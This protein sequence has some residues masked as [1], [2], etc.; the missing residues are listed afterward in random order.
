MAFLFIGTEDTDFILPTG[1]WGLDTFGGFRSSFVRCSLIIRQQGTYVDGGNP[2]RA[3]FSA[4]S[5][6]FW[7][8]ANILFSL[9]EQGFSNVFFSDAGK[10]RI[11][12]GMNSNN[13]LR[14]MTFDDA[15]VPTVLATTTAPIPINVTQRVDFKVG[16][17]VAG[18]VRVF[19]NNQEVITYNGDVTS[20]GSTTLNE[21]CFSSGSD[22]NLYFNEVIVAERDTRSLSLAVIAPNTTPPSGN[23][24]TG[25]FEDINESLANRY[26]VVYSTAA[27]QTATYGVYNP[28]PGTYSVRALKVSALAVRGE[29]GP[30][31]L[32]LG[33]VPNGGLAA[34]GPGL[35]LDTG[36]TQVNTVYETNPNTGLGWK[37]D[38]IRGCSLALRSK[39]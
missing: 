21:L 26:D 34:Y 12:I 27:D 31:Q 36:W 23:Q 20:G 1:G 5:S 32:Q 39:A 7:L 8:S 4:A 24:W 37:S 28:P 33:V 11:A 16:Y 17:A 10:K 19:V 2:V 6:N 18:Q 38:D 9:G 29:T 22:R 14:L 3:P 25:T 35:P 13:T 30:Q 15:G